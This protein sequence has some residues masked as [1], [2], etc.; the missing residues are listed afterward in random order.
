MKS[1]W[2]L[3]TIV[4][5]QPIVPTVSA[6][7][8]FSTS[9]FVSGVSTSTLRAKPARIELEKVASFVTVTMDKAIATPSSGMTSLSW[10][11][12][13]TLGHGPV[14]H[15]EPTPTVSLQHIED[16]SAIVLK[17]KLT[18][19]LSSAGHPFTLAHGP[20]VSTA[21]TASTS[22]EHS[23]AFESGPAGL[24]SAAPFP[25]ASRSSTLDHGTVI[26]TNPLRVTTLSAHNQPFAR[27]YGPLHISVLGPTASPS[28][29]E[30]L[31]TTGHGLVM[32]PEETSAASSPH[33]GHP[34]TLRHGP[35]LNSASVY[36]GHVRRHHIEFTVST[37]ASTF[38]TVFVESSVAKIVRP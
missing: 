2:L 20:V 16:S 30:H 27:G 10:D 36:S 34:F 3:S 24:T 12:P 22:H 21:A 29:A 31:F 25:T 17:P 15:T 11:H 14:I 13:F 23:F 28:V 35:V 6:P 7:V 32:P 38:T 26:P 9:D 37:P 8:T 5:R 19:S 1:N 4:A 33:E 18:T